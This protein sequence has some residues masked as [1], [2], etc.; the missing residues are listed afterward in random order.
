MPLRKW[1]ANPGYSPAYSE[2]V[3]VI[4]SLAKRVTWT[5]SPQRGTPGWFDQWLPS[6]TFIMADPPTP[7]RHHH[8]LGHQDFKMA[9][10]PCFSPDQAEE[11]TSS[12]H[13]SLGVKETFPR[14]LLIR[15]ILTSYWPEQ[16]YIPLKKPSIK[17]ELSWLNFFPKLN[18]SSNVGDKSRPLLKCGRAWEPEQKTGLLAGGREKC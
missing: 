1:R 16:G 18:I 11:I 14:S 9:T 4:E 2:I 8:H 15:F 12:H 13:A 7:R 17:R 6:T 3:C 10:A 5:R